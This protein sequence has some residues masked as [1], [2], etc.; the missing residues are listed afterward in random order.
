MAGN[1]ALTCLEAKTGN[2]AYR[3]GRVRRRFRLPASP[4]AYEDKVLIPSDE[5]ET[6]VVKAGP[7][8]EI[9]GTNSVGE[10]FLPPPQSRT[11]RSSTGE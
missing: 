6:F 2:V 9:I 1:G 5:G 4:V 8:H 7:T 3:G 10:L 11:A